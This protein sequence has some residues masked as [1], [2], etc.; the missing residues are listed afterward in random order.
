MSEVDCH[1][2]TDLRK[3]DHSIGIQGVLRKKGTKIVMEEERVKEEW[4]FKDV[5][6]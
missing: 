4:N 2:Q 1:K 6:D 5:L 3:R